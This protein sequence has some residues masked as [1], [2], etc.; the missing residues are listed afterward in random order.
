MVGHAAHGVVGDAGG[1]GAA[2]PGGI[3]E[4]RVETALASLDQSHISIRIE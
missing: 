4:E 1:E 2:R 3:G